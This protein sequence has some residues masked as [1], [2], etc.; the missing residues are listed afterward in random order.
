MKKRFLAMLVS[1]MVFATMLSPLGVLA[2]TSRV[3]KSYVDVNFDNWTNTTHGLNVN[4]VKIISDGVWMGN[5]SALTLS[6]DPERP[7]QSL[8]VSPETT[9]GQ[10]Y[11]VRARVLSGA[12]PSNYSS[13]D[14]LWTEFTVKYTGGFVGFG[15]GETDWAYNL[16]SI[17]KS[18]S[19]EIGTRWGYGEVGGGNYS[20]GTAIP[21]SQLEVG[22]WYHIA[23]AVDFTDASAASSGAPFHIWINGE[24]IC[25]GVR[26]A[27]VKP[28][29]AW[30]YH[31]MW[32]D[33]AEETGRTIYIDNL[34]LY[35]TAEVDT[36]IED[37]YNVIF[38][39]DNSDDYITIDGYTIKTPSRA[40][41]AD[42]KAAFPDA[43][44][45]FTKDG[46]VVA[47]DTISVE[48]VDV[49]VYSGNGMTFE[50]YTI[51]PDSTL[52]SVTVTDS[53]AE[54]SGAGEYSVGDTVTIDAGRRQGYR[55]TGW[56]VDG[57]EVEDATQKTITF[58]MTEGEKSFTA[59]WEIIPTY[60]VEVIDSLA[61]VSGAGAYAEGEEV[62]VDAGEM[63]GYEFLGWDVEGIEVE[64]LMAKTITFTMDTTPKSFTAKWYVIP[65]YTVEISGSYAE[66]SGAGEY[67]AGDIVTI[68]AG[69]K[70]KAEF[71][72]WKPSGVNLD[73]SY[74]ETT[75]FVMP[76]S[77]VKII[78]SWYTFASTAGG[79]GGGGGA[80]TPSYTIT[81]V[82]NGGSEV[83][84]VKIEKGASLAVELPVKEGYIFDSWYFDEAL[85]QRVPVTYKAEKAVTLYAGWIDKA[86][87]ENKVEVEKPKAEEEKWQNP[88]NDVKDSAWYF[89]AV[90][91]MYEKQYC[92]GFGWG[93][94]GPDV[95]LS[96]A[97]LV[98]IL[99]RVEGEPAVTSNGVFADVASGSW[100]ENAVA[101]ASANGI[102]TGYN[103]YTFA[104]DDLITR[105]QI[106]AILYRYAQMKG[107]SIADRKDISSFGDFW[108]VSSYAT[109]A[110]SWTV[111]NGYIGGRTE[112]ELAP[113]NSATR[114]EAMTI[115]YRFINK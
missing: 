77:N 53:D 100:Y 5:T 43:N 110:L 57:I 71:N 28:G 106:A 104:P 108:A 89:E 30:V 109:D 102:V 25:D 65:K 23:V 103:S 4:G 97:M 98:T 52:Y 40:T 85:T 41:V 63:V 34:K 91:Y 44:L 64:D 99:Y 114:A 21:D 2:D 49:R 68:S 96:R 50:E 82:T 29:S 67:F 39:D 75:T 87:L 24:K 58:T 60:A 7:G 74:N 76:E 11:Y 42:V 3:T 72:R 93:Q 10:A 13:C 92:D 105:E 31:K 94:F 16:V 84:P 12:L 83:A 113:Q 48:G 115:L 73:N 32:V 37:E 6:Q 59:N 78:A 36:H 86:E 90:K 15:F 55:F 17:N 26:T 80:S 62:T 95:S 79:G 20:R 51:V 101:W 47:D 9:S 107:Q 38:E 88:F 81:F 1:L 33:A 14:V 111:A 19:L 8:S 56:T 18:G 54:N 45:V 66:N 61:E 35:E 46:E 69:E 27:N 112:S 70:P 22:K